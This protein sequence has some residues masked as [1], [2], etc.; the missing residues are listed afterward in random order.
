MCWGNADA[1]VNVDVDVAC[2][3]LGLTG[4]DWTEL[5]STIQK[6]PVTLTSTPVV[7]ILRLSKG[8]MIEAE[9]HIISGPNTSEPGIYLGN[10]GTP[11][12]S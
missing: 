7:S 9:L 11:Y 1:R 6:A 3:P 10:P 4:L 8:F 12:V 5:D 2:V